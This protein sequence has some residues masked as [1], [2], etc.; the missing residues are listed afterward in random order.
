MGYK[1]CK[2]EIRVGMNGSFEQKRG[3]TT[4]SDTAIALL[5][6]LVGLLARLPAALRSGFPLND[7]GLFYRMILEIQANSFRL[8]LFTSYNAERIPFAYPPLGLY[9]AAFLASGLHLSVLDVLRI[10]PPIVSSLSVPVFYFLARRILKSEPYTALAATVAFALTPRAFEWQIMG[11]GI[12]RALGFL[13]ALL[14][15]YAACRLFQERSSRLVP[16]VAAWGALTVLSHPEAAVQCFLGAVL[17]YL[18]LDRSRAGAIRA[19]FAGVAIALLAAPWWATIL[20]RFGISPFVAAATAARQGTT[21]NFPARVFLTFQFSFTEEPFLPIISIL[22]LIGLFA[23]LARRS[24]LLP[25]WVTIPLFLEPRSA[26]QYMVVPLGMLAGMGLVEVVLPAFRGSGG[27]WL[28]ASKWMIGYLTLYLLLGAY[29]VPNGIAEKATLGPADRAAFEW[30]RNNTPK[31]SQFVVLTKGNALADPWVEWFPALA[32]RH[33]LDTAFGAE[34]LPGSIFAQRI[35][36]YDALQKCLSEDSACLDAWERTT[37][38]QFD[39]AVIRIT[40]DSAALLASLRE[41]P[42][43]ELAYQYQ[44]FAVFSNS[45]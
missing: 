14:T 35:R 5:A 39:Y 8:P 21:I 4:D 38:E 6:G 27:S 41:S 16:Q 1:Q 13:F 7:G 22:G 20:A 43:Y 23:E 3:V 44:S 34:W 12:T 26:P 11:G 32:Q 18:L 33:S 37:G 42:A 45:H 40:P 31:D 17:L 19:A 36:D 10:A 29:I 15:W 25:L 28:G 2:R 30:I 24:W 9:V